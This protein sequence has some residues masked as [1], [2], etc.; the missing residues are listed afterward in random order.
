MGSDDGVALAIAK[1]LPT[2]HHLQLIG[3]SMTN[4]GLEAILDGCPHL[5]SLDLRLCEYISLNE[6]LSSRISGQIKD[7]KCPHESLA[8][9]SFRFKAYGDEDLSDDYELVEVIPKLRAFGD[10]DLSDDYFRF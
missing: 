4:K 9:L 10:E 7:V 1:N 6:V 8:G 5:V 3:N 2:L